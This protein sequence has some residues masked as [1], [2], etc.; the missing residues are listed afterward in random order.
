MLGLNYHVVDMEFTDDPCRVDVLTVVV[1]PFSVRT[2][3]YGGFISGTSYV[4]QP[5]VLCSFTKVF[6][7]LKK[8]SCMLVVSLCQVSYIGVGRGTWDAK[9]ERR[10]NRGGTCPIFGYSGAAEGL[11][12]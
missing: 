11:K 8:A 10:K 7:P 2:L 6:G 3:R 1:S 9:S 12:P 4:I 5:K